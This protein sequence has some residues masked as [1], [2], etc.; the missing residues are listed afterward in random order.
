MT[1]GRCTSLRGFLFSWRRRVPPLLQRPGNIAHYTRIY[2]ILY[3]S[4]PRGPRTR[5]Q[6][7]TYMYTAHSPAARQ[8]VSISPIRHNPFISLKISSTSLIK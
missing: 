1:S 5:C 3:Y 6:V 8:S 2:I 7:Y 4:I